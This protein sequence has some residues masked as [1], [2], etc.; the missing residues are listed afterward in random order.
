MLT[1][2]LGRGPEAY[3]LAKVGSYAVGDVRA[4]V[5]ARKA[6]WSLPD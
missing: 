1:A 3:Q 2:K 4:L 6:D 5:S